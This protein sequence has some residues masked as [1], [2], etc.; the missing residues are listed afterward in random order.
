MA[1]SV[2]HVA[3][4]VTD[5]D[6]SEAFYAGVLGLAVLRRHDDEAGRPRSVWVALEGVFLALELAPE[7]GP[8]IHCLALGIPIS[9]RETWRTRL[10]LAGHPV[11]RESDFTLYTRDPDGNLIGLSHHPTVHEGE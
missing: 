8:S 11:E 6:R 5:L 1:L 3:L 7:G 10:E 9:E 2:H 4:R